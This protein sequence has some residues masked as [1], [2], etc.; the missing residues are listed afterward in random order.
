[1]EGLL[2]A[3]QQLLVLANAKIPAAMLPHSFI[4]TT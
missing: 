3:F 2:Q 1:M 4:I